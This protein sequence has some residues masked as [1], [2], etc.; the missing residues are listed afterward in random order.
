MLS[1]IK[2][3]KVA[4]IIALIVVV[5]AVIGF[6][7]RAKNGTET[8]VVTRGELVRTVELAGKVAPEDDADLAFETAG[9]VARTYKK[10]G[11]KVNEGEVIAELDSSSTNAD[12]LKAEADLQAARVELAKIQGGMSIESK[13]ATTRT[14]VVQTIRD[15]YT[16][17]DDALYSKVDQFFKDP[18]TPNPEIIFSFNDYALRN[19]INSSRVSIGGMLESWKARVN[20]LTLANYAQSDL[21][22]AQSNLKRLALFLD[23]VARAVSAFE[24]TPTLSQTTIDKYRTD[25]ASA[26]EKVNGA[27]AALISEGQGLTQTVSD[28]PVQAAKVAAAQAVAANYASR[29]SK[30]SLRSPISGIVAKQDAKAGEAVSANVTVASVISGDYKIEAYVPEV[31]VAGIKVGA[32]AAVTLDAYGDNVTF[33]ASITHIDPRETIRDGVSTYKIDLA[34]TASDERIRSG[35]TANIS[36]ETLREADR[37]LVPERAVISKSGKKFVLLKTGEKESVETE[38]KTGASDTEGH[39]EIVSG[40]AE[41]DVILLNPA[42]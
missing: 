12:Y 6:N 29:L 14:S 16:T 39:V 5:I 15:A 20:G 3:R 26:R 23:D 22:E 36:I 34:F 10:V 7:A 30:T 35:M 31:S 27:S 33:D 37:L 1:F 18:R 17:A 28:A 19:K 2:R 8:A 13:I 11:D 38:V 4:L 25:V 9:T 41:G 40:L 24:P 21:A 42:Q 32:K